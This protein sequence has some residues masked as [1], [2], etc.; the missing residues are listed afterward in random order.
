MDY[1]KIL[2]IGAVIFVVILILHGMTHGG[3]CW[4]HYD[5]IQAP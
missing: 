3:D 1:V 2:R 5:P 4:G